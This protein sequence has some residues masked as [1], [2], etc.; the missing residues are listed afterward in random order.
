MAT[1]GELSDAELVR[2]V[3]RG[4]RALFEE[5]VQRYARPCQW[6]L[7][8]LGIRDEE[9]LKDLVQDA[10]VRMYE[11]LPGYRPT[12]SFK[13]WFLTMTRNLGL[14]HHRHEACVREQQHLVA[15]TETFRDPEKEALDRIAVRKVLAG[16]SDAQREVVALKYGLDLT[17]D[18]IAQMLDLSPGTVKTHLFNARAR[19]TDLLAEEMP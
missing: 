13:A 11:K 2:E 1:M 16:L 9:L 3:V 8:N 17:C 5:L 10:F 12:G 15:E 7:R 4:N 14:N 18:E 6:V 19:L